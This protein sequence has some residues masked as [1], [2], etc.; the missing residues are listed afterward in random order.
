MLC[1]QYEASVSLKIYLQK[2]LTKES[3]PKLCTAMISYHRQSDLVPVFF[4]VEAL[5]IYDTSSTTT[6]DGVL[7]ISPLGDDFFGSP[8]TEE[9]VVQKHNRRENDRVGRPY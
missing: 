3:C 4:E 6:T 1:L 5:R 9:D 7:I 2:I 8:N